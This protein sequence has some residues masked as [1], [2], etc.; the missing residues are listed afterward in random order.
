[1]VPTGLV[2]FGVNIMLHFW[3]YSNNQGDN[4]QKNN[5]VILCNSVMMTCL[6]KKTDNQE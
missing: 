6:E 2:H 3:S 1:M 5:S 4:V